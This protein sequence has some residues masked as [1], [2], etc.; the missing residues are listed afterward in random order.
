MAGGAAGFDAPLRPTALLLL[1][2]ALGAFLCH[3]KGRLQ[4]KEFGRDIF[5]MRLHLLQHPRVYIE[6]H[7]VSGH[8][9]NNAVG[10]RRLNVGARNR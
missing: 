8:A 9:A 4:V 3:V 1:L 2:L 7:G 6:L 5:N 10:D